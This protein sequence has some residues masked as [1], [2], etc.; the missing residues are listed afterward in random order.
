M[1]SWL[2]KHALDKWDS[3]RFTNLSLFGFVPVLNRAHVTPTYG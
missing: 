3:A 2:T 1:E